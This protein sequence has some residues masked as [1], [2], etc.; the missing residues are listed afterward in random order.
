MGID[1]MEAVGCSENKVYGTVHTKKYNHMRNTQAYGTHQVQDITQW[2]TYALQWEEEG[3]QWYVDG[4][5]FGAFS[6][7]HRSS[8]RWPYSK[9][10]YLILNLAVGGNWGAS[11]L[12]GGRPSCSHGSGFR[13]GQVMEVDYVR[14][15][16]L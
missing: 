11:C 12:N 16:R 10:F 15:Y 8:E 9:E 3:L 4:E 6:P 13:R 7:T 2:H 5:L 14:V 1:I